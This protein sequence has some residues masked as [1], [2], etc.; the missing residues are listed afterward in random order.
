MRYFVLTPRS[1]LVTHLEQVIRIHAADLL[2]REQTSRLLDH[3]KRTSPVVVREATARLSVG[4]IQEVLQNLLREQVP[5][6]DLEAILE[7]ATEGAQSGLD[8]AALAQRA[9]GRLR[10]TLCQRWC[11]EDGRLLCVRL[12][13]E[14]E[15]AIGRYIAEPGGLA[16]AV[17]PESHRKLALAVGEGLAGL[18]KEGRPPVVVCAPGVRSAVH[19]LISPL[20]PRAVVLGYDELESVQIESVATIGTEL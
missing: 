10:R 15:E 9:R 7:A 18:E 17:S 6:R 2:T 19:K 3:L 14:T 20:L 11:A 4:Q 5:I 16:A 12:R 1:V 13:P 8:A